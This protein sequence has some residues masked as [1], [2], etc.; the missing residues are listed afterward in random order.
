MAAIN[1]QDFTMKRSKVVE[2]RVF[3]NTDESAQAVAARMVKAARGKLQNASIA[4]ANEYTGDEAKGVWA[5]L[6]S[7]ASEANADPRA[8]PVD[9]NWNE[10]KEK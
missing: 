5:A 10:I 1:Q 8:K 4:M 3:V 7:A 9:E 2:V 6:T